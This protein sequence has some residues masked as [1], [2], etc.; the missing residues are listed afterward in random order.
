MRV[1][2][3]GFG[4]DGDGLF[5]AAV[6]RWIVVFRRPKLPLYLSRPQHFLYFFPLPHGHG[7]FLPT[8]SFLPVGA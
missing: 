3:A 1:L 5:G 8:R 7:S 4:G 2:W 6:G